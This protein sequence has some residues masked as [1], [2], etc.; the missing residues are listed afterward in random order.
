MLRRNTDERAEATCFTCHNLD[1]MY[2]RQGSPQGSAGI[3]RLR[4]IPRRTGLVRPERIRGRRVV[5]LPQRIQ[6][7][8]T[9][10]SV[11]MKTQG[12]RQVRPVPRPGI[13]RGVLPAEKDGRVR[14]TLRV[15]CYPSEINNISDDRVIC[16][17][18]KGVF[19]SRLGHLQRGAGWPTHKHRRRRAVRAF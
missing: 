1:A 15:P 19:S 4:V 14:C 8:T 2:R 5:L 12:S 3:S 7:P 11:P 9:Y 10:T 18:Y 16:S 6:R 17:I 13:E